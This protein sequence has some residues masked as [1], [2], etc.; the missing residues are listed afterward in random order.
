[1]QNGKFVIYKRSNG[2]I[3]QCGNGDIDAIRATTELAYL[4]DVVA[5]PLLHR[6]DLEAKII[7][8]KFKFQSGTW[9]GDEYHCDIEVGTLVVWNG[10]SYKSTD[11][12][13]SVL[14]DQPSKHRL[15]LRH[16][17]YINGDFELENPRFA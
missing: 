7:V 12:T 15:L 17:L 2:Q 14:V 1:M 9:A 13:L 11:N 8:P 3:L 4:K 6:V 16:P 10:Q 5:D